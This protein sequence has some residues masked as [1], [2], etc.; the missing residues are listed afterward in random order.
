MF[1]YKISDFFDVTF[2]VVIRSMRGDEAKKV[3][4]E[5]ELVTVPVSRGKADLTVYR[6]AGSEVYTVNIL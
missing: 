3:C 1:N 5:I 6:D 2:H 4:P